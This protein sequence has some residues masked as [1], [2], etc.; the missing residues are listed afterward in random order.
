MK[1]VGFDAGPKQVKDL[2]DGLVQALIAQKPAEIGRLG[3]EQAYAALQGEP[4]EKEIGTD[5]EVITEDNL[6]EKQDVLYKP[7]C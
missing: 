7:S 2:E 5:F 6:A 4:T 3:V 1:I